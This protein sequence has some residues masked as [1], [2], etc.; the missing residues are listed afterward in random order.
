MID[1]KN[2]IND[3]TV[4]NNNIASELSSYLPQENPIYVEYFA[5]ENTT[6]KHDL[7]DYNLTEE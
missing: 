2:I 6:N 7:V 1:N 3:F 5:A 4:N